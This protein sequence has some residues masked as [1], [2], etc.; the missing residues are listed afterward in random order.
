M[1]L[2]CI[3]KNVNIYQMEIILLLKQYAFYKKEQFDV[4]KAQT[5]NGK[6]LTIDDGY[7]KIG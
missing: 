1:H 5:I 3:S 4:L 7:H 2:N 6:I